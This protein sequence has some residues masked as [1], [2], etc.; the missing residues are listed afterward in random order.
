MIAYFTRYPSHHIL[1]FLL[2]KKISP[3]SSPLI[4][5]EKISFFFF[6]SHRQFPIRQFIYFTPMKKDKE[7]MDEHLCECRVDRMRTAPISLH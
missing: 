3:L 4:K 6:T 2:L 1:E 5:R 7:N